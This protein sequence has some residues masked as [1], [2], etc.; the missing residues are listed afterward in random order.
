MVCVLDKRKKPLLPCSLKRARPAKDQLQFE[1]IL[2]LAR[3][4]LK[5]PSRVNATRWALDGAL[6]LPGLPASVGNMDRVVEMAGSSQSV[7]DITAYGRGAN[8][9][10]R[11]TGDDFLRGPLMRSGSVPL[12]HAGDHVRARV[13]KASRLGTDLGQGGRRETGSTNLKTTPPTVELINH[14]HGRLF[15]LADGYGYHQ[16]SHFQNFPARNVLA[17]RPEH[18]GLRA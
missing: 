3:Q 13:P 12:F 1:P 17:P 6:Q 10:T 7:I 4:P 16:A 18:P 8:Q 11:L 5:A 15:Q 2:R 9:R 14:K